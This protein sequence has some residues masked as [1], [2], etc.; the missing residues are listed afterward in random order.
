VVENFAS[1]EMP[2][3]G[4][5]VVADKGYHSEAVGCVTAEIKTCIAEPKIR[6]RRRWKDKSPEARAA[7][8][9]HRLRARSGYGKRLMRKRGESV[10]RSFAH[11]LETGGLRRTY[12]RG[13][14][15]IEKRYR[16]CSTWAS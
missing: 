3:T 6:G 2:S 10:E 1:V 15:N 5:T 4:F 16:A 11:M 13:R 9:R 14:E 8:R 12:L 7:F